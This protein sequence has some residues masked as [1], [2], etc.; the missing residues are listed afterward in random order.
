MNE[1]NKIQKEIKIK[2]KL[3][4]QLNHEEYKKAMKRKHQR[5]EEKKKK[6]EEEKEMKGITQEEIQ[7]T[8]YYFENGM[9]RVMPYWYTFT[10]NAKGRWIGKSIVHVFVNEFKLCN[11]TITKQKIDNHQIKINNQV[12]Q[13]D[14]IV[15]HHDVISHHIHRHEPPAQCNE[16]EIVKETDDL[17]VINKPAS[18]PVHPCGRFRHNTVIFI[19]AHKGYTQLKPLHRLD[20]MTSG[21]LCLAKN[22]KTAREF[23]DLLNQKIVRKTYLARVKGKLEQCTVKDKISRKRKDKDSVHILVNEVTENEGKECQSDFIPLFYDEKTDSTVVQVII[24][25][26]R[27]HQIRVH[28]QSIKHPILNDPIYACKFDESKCDDEGI[29]ETVYSGEIKWELVKGCQECETIKGDPIQYSIYLHSWKYEIDGVEYVTN[30]PYWAIE[31]ND[32][33]NEY[34]EWI[35]HHEF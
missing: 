18:I 8:E 23:Q 25:H 28:L 32:I 22:L 2:E 31:E 9:R 24:E 13:Y 14:T 1:E 17:L 30:K 27:T 12:I 10:V 15:K 33:S 16:I 7:E 5:Q 26:G 6:Q 35:S 34:K 20:R 4:H 29:G 11:E 21:I 19:L 3:E